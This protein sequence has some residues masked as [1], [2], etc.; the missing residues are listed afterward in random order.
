M[1][2]AYPRCA[3]DGFM[4]QALT[5]RNRKGR[6][7]LPC[8]EKPSALRSSAG[9]SRAQRK[10]VLIRVN[11][12]RMKVVFS[13]TPCLRGERKEAF[14]RDRKALPDFFQR[15]LAAVFQPEAHLPENLR[16][17]VISKK[18]TPSVIRGLP[19]TK[20][21]SPNISMIDRSSYSARNFVHGRSRARIKSVLIRVNP[22]PMK[23]FS[24]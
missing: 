16:T 3:K 1:T 6:H 9:R 21:R 18:R 15:I 17:M 20:R 14:A 19:D 11:P 12:W 4:A 7:H 8:L 2:D 23:L 13:V 10:S 5:K 22:W 24:Q